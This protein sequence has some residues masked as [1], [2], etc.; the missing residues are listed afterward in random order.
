MTNKQIGPDGGRILRPR[1]W[2]AA[3]LLGAMLIAANQSRGESVVLQLRN[4][5]RVSGVVVSE[6][7]NQLVLATEWSG[8][9]TLPTAQIVRRTSVSPSSTD[10]NA[11]LA[12]PIL[13]T[14]PPPALAKRWK[15]E[16]RV[17]LDFAYGIQQKQIYYGKFKLDYKRP[18][19]GDPKQSF[20]NTIDDSVDYGKTDNVRSDNR[21]DGGVNS[22]FDFSPRMFVYNIA[23]V[24]Y[25]QI[26]SIDVQYEIGPGLGYHLIQR[27]N[28]I[29]NLSLGADYQE[30]HLSDGSDNRIFFTRFAEDS[31]WQINRRFSMD[32]KLEYFLSPAQARARFEGNLKYLLLQNLSLNLTVEDLYDTQPADS[33]SQNELRIRSSLG[34]I[35]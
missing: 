28:F 33:V 22:E 29:A 9:I 30:R 17:G 31:R 10:T 35:F 4:G 5:D 19:I 3:L 16:A 13:G 12:L 14:N 27:T 34:I 2:L 11:F 23:R 21:M 7:T 15:M 8:K 24:G 1:G 20:R 32:Q 26:R 25:D 18:Y 6:A